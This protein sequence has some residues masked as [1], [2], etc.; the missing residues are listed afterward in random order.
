VKVVV[1]AVFVTAVA[2]G[3]WR[4]DQHNADRVAK[5]RTAVITCGTDPFAPVTRPSFVD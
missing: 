1:Y 2:W 5:I 4:F 3:G